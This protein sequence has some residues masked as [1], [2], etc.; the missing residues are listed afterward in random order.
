MSGPFA[1]SGN[2]NHHLTN[3]NFAYTQNRQPVL[4]RDAYNTIQFE[5]AKHQQR[6]KSPRT[7]L[8]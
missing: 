4:E 7:I 1:N 3:F 2:A 5:I 6:L 8:A